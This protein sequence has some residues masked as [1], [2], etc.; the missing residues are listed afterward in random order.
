MRV[1]ANKTILHIL[2][3]LN[4]YNIFIIKNSYIACIIGINNWSAFTSNKVLIYQYI[5]IKALV[6]RTFGK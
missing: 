4:L 3:N 1:K 5:R 2:I 6:K